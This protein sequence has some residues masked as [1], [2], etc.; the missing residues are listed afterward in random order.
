M[1]RCSWCPGE[2]GGG[3]CAPVVAAGALLA[4]A[5][6]LV[7]LLTDADGPSTTSS[8]AAP[9]TTTAGATRIMRWLIA[10]DLFDA[11]RLPLLTGLLVVGLIV[12]VVQGRRREPPRVV[13]GLGLVALLL[14]F[15]RPTLGP[16]IDLLPGAETCSSAGSSAGSTWRAYT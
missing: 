12:A 5:W 13:I 4:A 10:G 16:V 9:S 14:F 2:I 15:G 11:K 1:V 6:M 7:P 8:A 3:C